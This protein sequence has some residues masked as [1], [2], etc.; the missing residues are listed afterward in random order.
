MCKQTSKENYI[1]GNS[2]IDNIEFACRNGQCIPIESV[3]DGVSDCTLHEDEDYNLCSCG[4]DKVRENT[5]EVT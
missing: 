4:S 1:V 5:T 3:C 2:C